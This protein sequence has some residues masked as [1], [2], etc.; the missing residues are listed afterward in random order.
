MRQVKYK[1]GFTFVELI[2]TIAVLGIVMVM[3][4]GAFS[5]FVGNNQ[6]LMRREQVHYHESQARLALLGIVRDV[7][8]SERVL[9]HES[10]NA[11]SEILRLIVRA[12]IGYRT[13]MYHFS[14]GT[15]FR[16]VSPIHDGTDFGISS[17]LTHDTDNDWII[18]FIPVVLNDIK[19]DFPGDT[20]MEITIE[21]GDFY[22]TEFNTKV[23]VQRRP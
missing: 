7:R 15:L 13:I 1:N 10:G 19:I 22:G 3:V 11:N 17:N 16:R 8:H 14:E 18:N 12:G 4:V 20:H 5:G 21:S 9:E 2:I 23:S 6:V